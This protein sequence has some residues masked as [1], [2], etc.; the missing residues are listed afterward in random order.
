MRRR[1][2]LCSKNPMTV[3]SRRDRAPS[4]GAAP[5]LP[6]SRTCT[7]MGAGQALAAALHVFDTGPHKLLGEAHGS[8]PRSM[9][10][11]ARARVCGA[12]ASFAVG[13][14]DLPSTPFF[15]CVCAR[16]QASAAQSPRREKNPQAL[17][18][19]TS[20]V[21]IARFGG[22]IARTHSYQ[23]SRMF[24]APTKAEAAAIEAGK[25]MA[26][27]EDPAYWDPEDMRGIG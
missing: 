22:P 12:P 8:P 6:R 24:R 3:L 23:G 10:A 18:L 16:G 17:H 4:R 7:M 15:I 26:A 9:R 27:A 25:A 5:P 20:P 11:E 19:Q 1:T 13:D 2:H 14:R 21:P